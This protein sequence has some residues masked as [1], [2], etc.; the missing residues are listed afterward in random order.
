M[1]WTFPLAVR[2]MRSRGVKARVAGRRER[3]CVRFEVI[4]SP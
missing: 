3:V 4:I 1:R 2:R